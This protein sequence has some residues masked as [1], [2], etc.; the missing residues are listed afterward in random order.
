MSVRKNIDD[1][2]ISTRH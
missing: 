2:E 1:I